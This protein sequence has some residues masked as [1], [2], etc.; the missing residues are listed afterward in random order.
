MGRE[1]GWLRVGHRCRLCDGQLD[2]QSKG[3]T[4]TIGSHKTCTA[5][6]AATTGHHARTQHTKP[7]PTA[8]TRT[9]GVVIS[10]VH[11]AAQGAARRGEYLVSLTKPLPPQRWMYVLT[12]EIQARVIIN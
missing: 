3:Y 6:S 1:V 12:D 5:Y 7:H 9:I 2:P 8:L 4:I 10:M 11:A